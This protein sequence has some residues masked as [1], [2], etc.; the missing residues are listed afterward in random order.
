[1]AVTRALVHLRPTS[2]RSAET[3][4]TAAQDDR[5]PAPPP[6]GIHRDAIVTHHDA[7]PI[8]LIRL[9]P[10]R[11]ATGTQLVYLHGGAYVNPL[12]PFHWFLVRAL[13]RRTGATITMP[14]YLRAPQHTA[15]ENF[16]PLLELHHQLRTEHPRLVVAGDSAGAG[17]ALSLAIQ[18]RDAGQPAADALVL[19][20]PW[21]DVRT[22]HPGIAAVQAHDA[23]LH[24][25]GLIW[26]GQKWAG[27]L[28]VDDPRISPA[29]DALAALPPLSIH[30][31]TADIFAPDVE[32]FAARAAA[33]GT[34]VE[35][36]MVPGGFHVYMA[37]TGLPESRVT[38][39]R[40]AR[41]VRGA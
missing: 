20:S 6:R 9:Q 1:M 3:I 2:L 21:V 40:A 34:R 19:F 33:A 31:G 41:V 30:Q 29:A 18:A 23:M 14:L 7:G 32:D 10:R 8:P 38:L 13:L 24:P 22:N 17:L 25:E 5:D 12:D 15:A 39:D 27:T 37:V 35:L 26:A 36:E 28:P 4:A 11:A 16:G